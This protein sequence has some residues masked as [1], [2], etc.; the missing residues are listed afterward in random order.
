M[1]SFNKVILVGNLTRDPELRYTPK[2]M[3]IAKIGL[4]VNRVWKSETGE[5][6]EETTFV[7]IDAFGRTAEIVGQYLRKGSPALFEGRL[8]LDTWDDKQ[9]GQKRSKLNVV[10]EAV[11]L[12]GGR[13]AGEPPPQLRLPNPSNKPQPR[14]PNPRPPRPMAK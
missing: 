4:A 5:Q 7:D 13:P 9:T 8:R 3:A 1:A 11:Q 6:R 2:G 14:N 10:A 12:L